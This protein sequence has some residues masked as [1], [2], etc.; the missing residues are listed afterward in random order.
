MIT[1]KM[2]QPRINSPGSGIG[3]GGMPGGLRGDGGGGGGAN[4]GIGGGGGEA[5]EQQLAQHGASLWYT[6]PHQKLVGPA[7]RSAQSGPSTGVNGA[8]ASG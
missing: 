4:G 2:R 1:K 7:S 8:G 3:A 6:V 5:T